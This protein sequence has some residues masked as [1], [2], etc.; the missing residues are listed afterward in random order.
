LLRPLRSKG[1]IVVVDAISLR[2]PALLRAYQRSLLD[3]FPLMSV[4]T[5]TPDGRAFELMKS[6]VYALQM[7]L[8][9]SEF[10]SRMTD[11]V[12]G[13]SCQEY[14]DPLKM[15]TW[16]VDRVRKLCGPAASK[17]GIRTQMQV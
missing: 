16:L 10:S 3:V 11:L 8:E 14:S 12:D 2:H 13:M 1:C 4:V 15:S 7:N 5:L 17:G 9:E 6:M